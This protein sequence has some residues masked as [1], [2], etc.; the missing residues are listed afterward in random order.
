[1]L[2]NPAVREILGTL[3]P[4]EQDELLALVGRAAGQDAWRPGE[5]GRVP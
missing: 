2:I 1:M 5:Q 4:G 3:P